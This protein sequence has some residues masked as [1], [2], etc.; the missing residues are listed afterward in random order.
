MFLAPE[1]Q[2]KTREQ[3]V[4]TVSAQLVSKTQYRV[5]GTTVLGTDCHSD[6]IFA[7]TGACQLYPLISLSHTH[8]TIPFIRNYLY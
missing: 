5:G 3:L 2:G 7:L 1:E 4:S 6:G 8:T